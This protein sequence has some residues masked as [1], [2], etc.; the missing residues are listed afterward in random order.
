MIYPFIMVFSYKNVPFFHIWYYFP[1][2]DRDK[3]LY[4]IE[5]DMKYKSSNEEEASGVP[6]REENSASNKWF[7]NAM[8]WLVSTAWM[9]GS[10]TRVPLSTLQVELQSR[11]PTVTALWFLNHC[12]KAFEIRARISKSFVACRMWKRRNVYYRRFLGNSVPSPWRVQNW[13]RGCFR[14][15]HGATWWV[16]LIGLLNLRHEPDR[17]TSFIERWEL[18]DEH[19]VASVDE[20]EISVFYLSESCK[21][22]VWCYS[23]LY[24][25]LN[26]HTVTSCYYY[27]ILKLN[28]SFNFRLL[29]CPLTVLIKI[30]LD[31]PFNH[32][33]RE[34]ISHRLT[35]L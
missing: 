10:R 8:L 33:D 23:C 27:F 29:F 30:R 7:Q 20:G 25:T 3:K 15:Y 34:R 13:N 5:R 32:F 11:S 4:F 19:D 16:F 2:L 24:P 9:H 31:R 28:I 14:G 26:P 12:I 18:V 6:D 21:C 22:L 35:S 17:A 1:T